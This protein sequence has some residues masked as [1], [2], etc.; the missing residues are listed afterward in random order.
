MTGLCREGQPEDQWV[1]SSH[2]TRS[3]LDCGCRVV[4]LSSI[5]GR[6][7]VGVHLAMAVYG[8]SSEEINTIARRR[9]GSVFSVLTR[10]WLGL[11]PEAHDKGTRG[12]Y[13]PPPGMTVRRHNAATIMQADQR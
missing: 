11:S 4:P 6:G 13:R 10:S 5:Y 2:A 3:K 8:Q 12:Q 9:T 1:G 7:V